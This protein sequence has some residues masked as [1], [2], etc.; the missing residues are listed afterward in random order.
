M[1]RWV[2]LNKLEV[3]KPQQKN[4]SSWRRFWIVLKI[5]VFSAVFVLETS[6]EDFSAF[7]LDFVSSPSSDLPDEALPLRVP[8]AERLSVA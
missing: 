1:A 2:V 3:E 6:V 4:A 8:E 5:Y 7:S